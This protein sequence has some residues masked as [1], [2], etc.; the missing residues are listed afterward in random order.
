MVAGVFE[1]KCC[2][3]EFRG[4]KRFHD[5]LKKKESL[6]GCGIVEKRLPLH[7][8]I[9]EE[10]NEYLSGKRK[11]FSV[12]IVLKGTPFQ[13]K[14]WGKLLEIPYGQTITYS[15]LASRCN[16]QNAIRAVGAANGAN[17]IAIMVPCHRVIGTDGTLHGYGGGI[18]VKRK[19]LDLEKKFSVQ[20]SLEVFLS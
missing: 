18:Q 17:N 6:F 13:E 14:V 2:L 5:I 4:R 11:E 15:E 1:D 9:E 7:F 3:L 12:P 20:D 16:R 19:L 8:Q 10:L